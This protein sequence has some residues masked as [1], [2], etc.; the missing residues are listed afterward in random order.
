MTPEEII[1]H[2][3]RCSINKKVVAAVERLA[4]A[5]DETKSK[6]TIRRQIS[7][8]RKFVKNE[9]IDDRM[10]AEAYETYC[11]LIWVIEKTNWTPAGLF[12]ERIKN[13]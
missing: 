3:Q 2:L 7:E 5:A 11:G 13:G 10:R 1:A 12:R 4:A 6:S 9:A 8:L